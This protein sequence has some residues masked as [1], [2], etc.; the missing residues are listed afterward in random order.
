MKAIIPAAG[1]G[2]RCLPATK[3]MPK[4]M[5]PVV[6]R[7]VI[8]YVVEEAVEAGC[9]DILIVTG[10]GK[11]SI[12]DHFDKSFEL[13]HHLAEQG[14]TE[15]LERVQ[16]IG[17]LAR[18]HYVRQPEPRGLGDA[19][20]CAERFVGE[21]PF[22]V[23]LGDDI[24][25]ADT[26][27]T[28]QLLDAYREH[29]APAISVMEVAASAVDRYGI[30]DPDPVEDGLVEIDDMVEKPAPDQAPS[31]LASIGRYVFEPSIFDALREITPGKGGELQLTD[32][33]AHLARARDVL[34]VQ[35]GGQRLD[36][37]SIEGF[38]EAN[39]R[40]AAD[41]EGLDD[42]LRT[43]ITQALEDPDA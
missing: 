28:E 9:E 17:E 43:A 27:P 34:A 26:T 38:L 36:V 3:S 1:L 29:G 30:V 24:M 21:D 39:L 31:Q 41:H 5:L 12:E 42:K 15:E 2:T 13:E 40:L 20:L 14:K 37:G 4:E 6:D 25:R 11:R 35:Y 16:A 32:A 18:V 7:P 8:Q 23:L 19:I 10:R 22:A 33:I